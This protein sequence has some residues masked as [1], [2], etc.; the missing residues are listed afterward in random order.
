[1]KKFVWLLVGILIVGVALGGVSIAYAGSSLGT[2][3]N[4]FGNF[5]R[6]A[7]GHGA[8]VGM[9]ETIDSDIANFI[10]VTVDDLR[11]AQESGKS[12]ATIATEHGKTEDAL[13]QFIILKETANLD[14]LLKDAK[15]TQ[16]QHDNEVKNMA[17][18]VKE[19]VER[20]ETGKP[21]F[22][23]RGILGVGNLDSDI[24]NFIGVTVDDLRTAQESG[25]SLATI[26]TEHGKTEDALIQFIILK[27]TANLDTLLKDAKITQAQHDNEVKNMATQV[28]E[29][30]ERIET[31]K[32]GFGGRG[33]FG[34]CPIPNNP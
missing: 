3:T 13:I 11:T 10:G 20:I 18:Q 26:A 15:I 9:N 21:G 4:G 29:M 22:G 33:N 34:N 1:M 24:A 25:K 5:I 17:T 12:L 16:A 27:E 28:K 14:T 23:G 32:P 6:K 2:T 8:I 30:V 31:G 19:M 7:F